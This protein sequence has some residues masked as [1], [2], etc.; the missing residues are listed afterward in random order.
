MKNK[1]RNILFVAQDPGGWNALSPVVAKVNKQHHVT[2]LLA[3]ESVAIVQKEK[4]E[5]MD[6]T[7]FKVSKLKNLFFSCKPDIIVV[8]TSMGNSLE[9]KMIVLAKKS[10]IPVIAVVDFWTH[11]ADRFCTP[12]KNDWKYLPDIVCAIDTRMKRNMVKCGIPARLIQITGNPYFD[13]FKI[14]T[15]KQENFVLFVE[16][17]FTEIFLKKRIV[18]ESILF[19]E[20]HILEDILNARDKSQLQIPVQIAFHPKSTKKDKFQ[21]CIKRYTDV[22]VAKQSTAMLVKKAKLVIGMNSMVLCEAAFGGKNVISYQ[23]GLKRKLD[24]LIT[25]NIGLSKPIYNKKALSRQLRFCLEKKTILS[26]ENRKVEWYTDKQ[27]T[28]RVIN[29]I[30]TLI[31]SYE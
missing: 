18:N 2:L 21:E 9:K 15:G 28:N 27:A 7:N 30:D 19:N 12:H 20:V 22:S 10:R 25:N 14:Y 3:Q 6:C 1:K 5:Y 23:P 8:G 24:P 29:L 26:V 31:S 17:P 13:H 4:R 11:Y 16:Q